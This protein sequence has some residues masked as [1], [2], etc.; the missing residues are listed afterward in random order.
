MCFRLHATAL[1]CLTC[2]P[3]PPQGSLLGLP[4][5]RCVLM[6]TWVGPFCGLIPARARK[7]QCHCAVCCLFSVNIPCF[8]FRCPN[9]LFPP[10]PL[11]PLLSS[12]ILCSAV[13][14]P[15]RCNGSRCNL[16]RKLLRQ[17]QKSFSLKL[18]RIAAVPSPSTVSSFT[19]YTGLVV[20]HC[21]MCW[22]NYNLA[23]IGYTPHCHALSTP[24]HFWL[25]CCSD[26][27]H[28]ATA[29]ST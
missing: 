12:F 11:Y 24:W 9:S 18:R 10:P 16:L 8:R 14:F 15:S 3:A 1:S 20:A 5:A 28:V 25:L 7:N 26:Y 21:C 17:K 29:G 2:P 23:F 22:L 27:S 6:I 13:I 19:G 4:C